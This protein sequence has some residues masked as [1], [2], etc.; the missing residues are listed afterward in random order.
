MHTYC[1]HRLPVAFRR[2]HPHRLLTT[3][4]LPAA[5]AA[6]RSAAFL[7]TMTMVQALAEAPDPL[8]ID[9]EPGTGKTVL[10]RQIHQSS[11]LRGPFVARAIPSI[12]ESL[13]QSI[14]FDHMR[15]TFTGASRDHCGLVESANGGT[16]FFDE[17]GEATDA[18]QAA[19]LE[20]ME[21]GTVTRLGDVRSRPV[22]VR[23][24]AATN[25]DLDDRM[26][27]GLFRRDL[28]HR[29]GDFRIMMPPLRERPEEI[30]AFFRE[31][32]AEVRVPGLAG[33]EPQAVT[34]H[35]EVE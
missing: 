25:A 17:I 11:G 12:P 30:I 31:F 8:L 24:V 5:L 20:V 21:S 32:V 28:L 27:R 34:L 1:V 33:V 7:V 10:A 29:F 4:T 13:Q 19:F 6:G 22:S 3:M 23:I 14:I 18:V 26:A 35:R 15:G 2:P 16:L 9:G